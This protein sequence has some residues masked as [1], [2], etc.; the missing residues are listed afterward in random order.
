MQPTKQ[1]TADDKL[2][3]IIKSRIFEIKS[4][5]DK[6]KYRDEAEALEDALNNNIT[7]L[8]SLGH[9]VDEVA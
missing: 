7:W 3:A 9:N 1:M 5:L 6:C 4:K 2:V 8:I